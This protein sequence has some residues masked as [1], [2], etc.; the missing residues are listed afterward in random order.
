MR[1]YTDASSRGRLSGLGIVITDS[2]D[3]ELYKKGT[4]IEEPDNNTAELCAILFALKEVQYL[5]VKH[6]TIFTDSWY[7][8]GAIRDNAKRRKD[9]NLVH[10]IRSY[11]SEINS[12]LM[13]VKG[14]YRGGNYLSYYNKRADKMSKVVRRKYEKIL[15]EEKKRQHK[16]L[17]QTRAQIRP[18]STF[19]I[20]K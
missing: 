9:K 20:E 19:S 10:E 17:Q 4:V 16:T 8:I 7:A 12:S 1:I 2:R 5:D 15:K 13:W 11:M 14:H 3:R 6:V 18:G